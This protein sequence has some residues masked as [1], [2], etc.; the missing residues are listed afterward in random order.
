MAAG[1][2]L[3][4]ENL[5]LLRARLNELARRGLKPEQLQPSLRLDAEV[6]LGQVSFEC[7]SHLDRLNPIGQGNP[8]VQLFALNLRHD[9]PLQR[10]GSEKQHVKMWV[11]DGVATHEAVWW[12]A[13]NES[14]PVGQY[15]LAFSPQVNDYN[16]NR[17][18]QLKVLDW[19]PSQSSNAV[20]ERM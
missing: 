12:G 13:G 20:R 15:D 17:C 18:V 7:L 5:D 2:T 8:P 11:T 6:D 9:R 3:Q 19:R 14:L 16:G 4:S 10:M 1:L